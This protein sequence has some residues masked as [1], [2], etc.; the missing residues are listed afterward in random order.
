MFLI[1]LGNNFGLVTI[2]WGQAGYPTTLQT[3]PKVNVGILDSNDFGNLTLNT[4]KYISD[5]STNGA[6]SVVVY[7][8]NQ[9]GMPDI[10]LASYNETPFMELPSTAYMSNSKGSFDKLVIPDTLLAHDA[11]LS[12]I[13]GKPLINFRD[14]YQYSKLQG[15]IYTYQNGAFVLSQGKGPISVSGMSSAITFSGNSNGYQYIVSDYIEGSNSDGTYAGQNIKVYSFDTQSLDFDRN[16]PIQ[17]IVPYLSTLPEYKT[18]P[19]DIGGPGM[20]HVYRVWAIDLNNDGYDDILAGT[21]MWTSTRKPFP[22]ALE[23]LINKG[24]GTFNEVTKKLNPDII[25]VRLKT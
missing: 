19:A 7:D 8:F 11:K 1:K 4:S 10:F 6:T 12:V 15:A 13:N 16:K 14:I 22:T 23:I 17:T 25:S 18:F 5:P 3:P 2:G 24:N 21:S 20:T 9:D